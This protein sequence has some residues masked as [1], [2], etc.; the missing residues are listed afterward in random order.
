MLTLS[1]H[2]KTTSNSYYEQ[3]ERV[4]CAHPVVT[5]HAVPPRFRLRTPS[6]LPLQP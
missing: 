4:T 2:G 3:A 1:N 5:G 6:A